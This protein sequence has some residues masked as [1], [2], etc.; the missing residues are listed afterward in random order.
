MSNTKTDLHKIVY[1]YQDEAGQIHDLTIYDSHSSGL[2]TIKHFQEQ[3]VK[4]KWSI[5]SCTV[6]KFQ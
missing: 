4:N 6:S 3:R 1:R 2:S 5:L